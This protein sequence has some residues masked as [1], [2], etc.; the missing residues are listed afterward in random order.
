MII[1]ILGEGQYDVDDRHLDELNDLDNRLHAAVQAE[2]VAA[3][4]GSLAQ[5]LEAVRRLGAPLPDD[6]LTV[7]ELVIP[8]GDAD[9]AQVR[10]LL[11]NDGLIPG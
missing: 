7:S 3:F 4:G 9:L 11:R 2:D 8:A 1:R 6:V 10:A 5:L